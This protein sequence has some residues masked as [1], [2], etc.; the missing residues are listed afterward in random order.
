MLLSAVLEASFPGL[1]LSLT[2]FQHNYSIEIIRGDLELDKIKG[3]LQL[4]FLSTNCVQSNSRN[5]SLDIK[6][7]K[8]MLG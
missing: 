6:S 8:V 7:A 4:G 2:E 1:I 5:I 3:K